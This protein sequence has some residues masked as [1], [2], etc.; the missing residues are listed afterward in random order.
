MRA[1]L[2]RELLGGLAAPRGE[3]RLEV[4]GDRGHLLALALVERLRLLAAGEGGA[5][6]VVEHR[7]GAATGVLEQPGGLGLGPAPH[8]LAMAV[9]V[10]GGPLR[11]GLG[12]GP[13]LLRLRLGAARRSAASSSARVRICPM[14]SPRS[15]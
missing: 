4:G 13:E 3:R 14:R 5:V 2:G 12:R 9:G 15:W 10:G 8:L 11:G 6:G 7:V 1:E